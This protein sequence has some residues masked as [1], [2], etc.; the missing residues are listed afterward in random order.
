MSFKSDSKYPAHG[1]LSKMPQVFQAYG[2]LELTK[3]I[4]FTGKKHHRSDI[5]QN[6]IPFKCYRISYDEREEPNCSVQI[7][8]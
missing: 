3:R 5:N 4:K 1:G 2:W 8:R 6:H 7:K